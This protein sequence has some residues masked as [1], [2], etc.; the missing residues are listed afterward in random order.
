VPRR[1]R[2]GLPRISL[3]LIAAI[4]LGLF[5]TGGSF[6]FAAQ[7]EDHDPFCASCHTQ[8]ETTYVDRGQAASAVDLA[9]VHHQHDATRCIDCH[10]GPGLTGRAQTIIQVGAVDLLAYV[11]HTAKQPAQ[12][13]I[14][15]ADANCLKCHA[16]VTQTR[17]FNR[18][19]HAFLAR[20]QAVDPKAA[21][22]VDC[23]SAHTTDGD[24]TAT[25]LQQ[26]R[27]EAVCQSCHAVRDRG[28]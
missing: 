13:T 8:P 2:A 28:G 9:S 18:H 23:H 12:L 3:L 5:I 20:W 16:E 25:F 21:T 24:P 14:P 1:Q 7:L 10:S 15:I 6:A 17:S 22:C 27:T 11:T 19:F 4:L 26:A